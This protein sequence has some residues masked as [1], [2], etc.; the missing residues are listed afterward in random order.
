MLCTQLQLKSADLCC[1]PSV[2][3]AVRSW[4]A[5]TSFKCCHISTEA[6]N[7]TCYFI[8]PQYTDAWPTSPSTDP[9]LPGIWQGKSLGWLGQE[10][11]SGPPW[12]E[13]FATATGL[14]KWVT[15]YFFFK[16]ISSILWYKFTKYPWK[17]NQGYQNPKWNDV[18]C[19]HGVTSTSYYYKQV[20]AHLGGWTSSLWEKFIKLNMGDWTSSLLEK[21]IK[22]NMFSADIKWYT[23][24][25]FLKLNLKSSLYWH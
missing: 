16:Y 15:A 21:F 17:A 11:N 10:S 18:F 20:P 1:S 5:F 19:A 7:Q 6:A 12:L 3:T 9:I 24:R 22:L 25:N 14:F 8:Q 23:G 2:T 4:L 13:S